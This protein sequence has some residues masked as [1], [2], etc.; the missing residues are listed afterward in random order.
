MCREITIQSLRCSIVEESRRHVGRANYSLRARSTDAPCVFNCSSFTQYIFK[1]CL[2]VAI[3]RRAYQ[4]KEYGMPVENIMAGDLV[5]A[6]GKNGWNQFSMVGHVGIATG[7][8]NIIHATNM[9][10]GVAEDSLEEFLMK[11]EFLGACSILLV[12]HHLR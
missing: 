1:T 11:R 7:T 3:P 2:S 10:K 8:G 4:Q 6:T 5:F 9:R 12:L